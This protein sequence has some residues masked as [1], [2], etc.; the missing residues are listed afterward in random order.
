MAALAFVSSAQ[1]IT[2]MGPGKDPMTYPAKEGY[3]LVNN[4]MVCGGANGNGTNAVAYDYW[5][6]L[7]AEMA[8]PDHCMTGAIC[9]DYAYISCSK[10]LFPMVDDNGNSFMGS[11]DG[12]H[13]IVLDRY[14][15][16][17]VKNMTLTLN[18]EQYCELLGTGS[19]GADDFGHLWAADCNF[20]AYKEDG[21]TSPIHLYLV[22]T[23]TGA[24]TDVLNYELDDIEGPSLMG[25][26]EYY[27]LVGDITGEQAQC[28]FMTAPQ[29]KTYVMTFVRGQGADAFVGGIDPDDDMG[30]IGLEITDTDPAEQ[31]LWSSCAWV[32]IVPDEDFSGALFWADGHQTYPALYDRDGEKVLSLVSKNGEEGWE[33]YIPDRSAAGGLAHF[34]LGDDEFLC[35]GL[36][37]PDNSKWGGE[38]AL[39]KLDNNGGLDNAVPMHIFPKQSAEVKGFGTEKGQ[40]F[41][42]TVQAGPIMKDANGKEARHI[43]AYKDHV[44]LALYTLAQEGYQAGVEGIIADTNN[45][46]VEYF[47]LN[48]VRVD[49]NSLVPGLYITRQGE[50]ASKVVVK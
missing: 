31:T 18:G 34:T 15:G 14:S 35:Y 38:V 25:R 44:G 3:T 1:D 41:F 48:G 17:F 19:I 20:G 37:F 4:W 39:V 21:T 13:L 40:R 5:K 32:S 10:D 47:N 22:N 28:V 7:Y 6:A 11:G 45:A 29:D 2:T 30:M 26:F 42:Q 27:S 16:K 24:L 43:F 8:S 36:S 23:E 46:P 33:D 49:A 9:G 50:K 12:S